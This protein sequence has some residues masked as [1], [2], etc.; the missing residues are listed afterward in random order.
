[1][2]YL[3]LNLIALFIVACFNNLA[4]LD[5]KTV[6]S[7]PSFQ[8]KEQN[9]DTNIFAKDLVKGDTFKSGKESYQI[10]PE[11][12]SVSGERKSSVLKKAALSQIHEQKSGS[13]LK[14]KGKFSIYKSARTE[15]GMSSSL[16]PK[17]LNDTKLYPIVLNSR[18]GDVGIVTGT[19]IVKVADI[20]DADYLATE[21]NLLVAK[22][23]ERLNLVFFTTPT[24]Q[25]IVKAKEALESDSRVNEATIEIL[26]RFNNAK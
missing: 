17:E 8:G 16:S 2:K 26:E 25:D 4:A 22:S 24:D 9:K 19:I 7:N 6:E 10:L 12:Y 21:Y 15:K 14:N 13:H 1:M 23:Y 18:T 11:L 5:L 3:T 20:E